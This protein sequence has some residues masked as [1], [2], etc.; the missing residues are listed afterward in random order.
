VNLVFT[1]GCT[2]AE[3]QEPTVSQLRAGPGLF[4]TSYTRVC[5][6]EDLCNDLSTIRS[7][8]VPP[9]NTGARGRRC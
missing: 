6:H 5:R 8:W 2:M 3:D 4:I 9:T 1:K 7:L